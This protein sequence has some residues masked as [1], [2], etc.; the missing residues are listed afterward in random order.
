MDNSSIIIIND[1][2]HFAQNLLALAH[3]LPTVTLYEGAILDTT[4]QFETFGKYEEGE[5]DNYK[6]AVVIK[7]E[8][9]YYVIA[10]KNKLTAGNKT[11]KVMSSIVLKK[12]RATSLTSVIKEQIKG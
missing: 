2:P 1:K 3:T 7:C 6:L 9:A 4:Y 11:V 12:A 8:G 10:G 5:L